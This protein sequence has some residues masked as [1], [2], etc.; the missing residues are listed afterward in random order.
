M[1]A[2]T[3]TLGCIGMAL[4]AVALPAAAQEAP[5]PSA[6]FDT[7]T[8]LAESDLRAIAGREDS[9]TQIAAADQRNTVQNNSVTGNSVTGSVT[10]DGQAFQ[11]MSG[12]AVI[13]ANSG[14]NVAINSAMNVV[15][16]LAPQ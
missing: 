7:D 14:N 11:N 10:L 2:S 13:N 6:A 1:R 9:G 15:I 5:A 4:A 8:A 3:V 16:N 12:L